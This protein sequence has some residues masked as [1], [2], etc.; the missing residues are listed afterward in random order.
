MNDNFFFPKRNICFYAKKEIGFRIKRK[1]YLFIK[2]YLLERERERVI[3][4]VSVKI[5]MHI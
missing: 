5:I 1:N 3:K 4:Y 2:L